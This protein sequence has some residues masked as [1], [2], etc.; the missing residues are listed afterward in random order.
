M[1]RI[2]MYPPLKRGWRRP[3]T[4]D[5][6]MSRCSLNP[7]TECWEWIGASHKRGYGEVRE[8][9]KGVRVSRKAYELWNGE[10]P[11][12]MEVMHACDNPPCCNPQHLKLG[13]H[14]DN[15]L[16]ASSKGRLR[17]KIS[18]DQVEL[19][20]LDPR[21]YRIISEDYGISLALISSIKNGTRRAAK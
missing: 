7:D 21:F 6:I 3:V 1:S 12:G 14:T 10:I 13:T 11:N 15:M 20:K 17:R 4:K 16:D 18:P 8:N 9:G 5:L 2:T 19:V